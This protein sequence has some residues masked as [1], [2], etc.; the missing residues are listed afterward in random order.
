MKSTYDF[1]IIGTVKGGT[2]TLHYLLEDHPDLSLPSGK[3]SPLFLTDVTDREVAD[4]VQRHTGGK[5]ARLAGKATPL[6]MCLPDVAP[7]IHRAA[8]D[9]KLI[10]LLRDPVTRASSHWRMRSRFGAEKRPLSEA[11]G[12][13]LANPFKW[14]ETGVEED[15]Y[16]AD[17]EYGRIL[18][19][20]AEYFDPSQ[21]L[22]LSASE[23][24]KD[25]A[26]VVNRVC[27]FLGVSPHTPAALG[28]EFNVAERT[29]S[30]ARVEKVLWRLVPHQLIART[31]GPQLQQRAGGVLDR[32]K[33]SRP[34]VAIDDQVDDEL[35]ERLKLHYLADAETLGESFRRVDVWRWPGYEVSWDVTEGSVR[36]PTLDGG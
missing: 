24:S 36:P 10:A 33:I 32:Y 1:L 17:G 26:D 13:Q 18:N 8:P 15:G 20:Y 27:A 35:A 6:Y 14:R 21:I 22:V 23:L 28:M 25:P 12:E 29:G 34:A 4:H 5:A 2:T 7:R 16:V 31:I 11:L 19:E 9:T 3:E 30:R